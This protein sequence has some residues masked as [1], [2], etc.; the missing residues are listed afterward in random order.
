MPYIL[1][2]GIES[3]VLPTVILMERLFLVKLADALTGAEA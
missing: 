2:I 3:G 1:P